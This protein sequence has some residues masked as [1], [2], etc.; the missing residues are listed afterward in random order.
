MQ[1]NRMLAR[2]ILFNLS[3]ELCIV[4]K[5]RSSYAECRDSTGTRQGLS[6]QSHSAF[7]REISAPFPSFHLSKGLL[8][9]CCTMALVTRSAHASGWLPERPE[10]RVSAAI[11]SMRRQLLQTAKCWSCGHRLVVTADLV[12]AHLHEHGIL[13]VSIDGPTQEQVGTLI[14][15][16]PRCQELKREQGQHGPH[17]SRGSMKKSKQ[18]HAEFYIGRVLGNFVVDSSNISSFRSRSMLT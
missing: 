8:L 4:D 9:Q 11:A 2:T 17:G 16:A 18:E 15:T 1:R 13:L 6:L 10:S 3:H 12:L 14:Q 5:T 7:F